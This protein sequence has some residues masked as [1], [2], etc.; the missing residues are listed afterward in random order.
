MNNNW[1]WNET[2]DLYK[3]G[4]NARVLDGNVANHYSM[5]KLR[6]K[7]RKLPL[8]HVSLLGHCPLGRISVLHIMPAPA[9]ESD[10]LR[11]AMLPMGRAGLLWSL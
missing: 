6:L 5:S 9:S 4:K 7:P 3:I 11:L 8:K 10:R 2:R 1:S